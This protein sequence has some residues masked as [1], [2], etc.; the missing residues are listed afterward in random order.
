[1][2]LTSVSYRVLDP[3]APKRVS[4]PIAKKIAEAIAADAASRSPVGETGNLRRGWKATPE[5]EAQ[6]IVSNAVR[7]AKFVEFGTRKMQPQPML[8]PALMAARS[9]VGS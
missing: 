5:A 4:D 6:W 3:K 9:R 2:A 1:M 8:G 7:Y